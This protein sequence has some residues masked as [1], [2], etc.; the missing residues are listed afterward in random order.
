[1]RSPLLLTLAS[2]VIA[3][4]IVAAAPQG[5]AGGAPPAPAGR[6][7]AP[8]GRGGARGQAPARDQQQAQQTPAGTAS[9]AGTVTLAGS[10]TPVRHAQVTLSGSGRGGR[11]V[12]TNDQGRFAFVALPS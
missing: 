7:T 8:G 9:I 12:S 2:A 6:G 1:M 4:A 10:A 11:T 5:P 3:G